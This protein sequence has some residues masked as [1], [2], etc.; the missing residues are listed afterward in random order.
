MHQLPTATASPASPCAVS[1][2][3]VTRN[4]VP[5]VPGFARTSCPESRHHRTIGKDAA[6]EARRPAFENCRPP[7]N[8]VALGT[9]L[10]LCVS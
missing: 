6:S 5:K 7:P 1:T 9:R 2:V 3:G 4:S 10:A 8:P